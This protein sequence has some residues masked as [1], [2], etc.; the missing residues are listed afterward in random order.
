MISFPLDRFSRCVHVMFS[1]Q[2][3]RAS[4]VAV[5]LTLGGACGSRDPK[6]IKD[7]S[8]R[9]GDEL[10]TQK[11]YAEALEAYRRGVEVN[12]TDSELRLKLGA[13]YALAGNT[14]SAAD[15]LPEDIDTQLQ[16]AREML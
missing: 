11:R 8:I 15:L 3:L 2:Y 4:A 9:Q 16:A 6:V 1:R 5:L 13:A 14:L 7:E 10:V 12:P